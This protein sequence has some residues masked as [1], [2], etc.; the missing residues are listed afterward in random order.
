MR[1]RKKKEKTDCLTYHM[2]FYMLSYSTITYFLETDR[3][4]SQLYVRVK[5]Y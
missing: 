4:I 3:F 2:T 5:E 1:E